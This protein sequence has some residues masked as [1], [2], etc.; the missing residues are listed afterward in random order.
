ML[1]SSVMYC[2][3]F[4]S[5]GMGATLHTCFFFSVLMMLLLPTFGYPMNP[6]EICFL[7]L[8]SSASCR[9]RS[10]SAALPKQCWKDAWYASVGYSSDSSATHFFVH[11]VGTRSHLFSTNTRCLWRMFF[12]R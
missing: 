1:R 7:S 12:F 6:T 9:S 3:T 2:H 5:P 10:N 4:V 11:H 8:C